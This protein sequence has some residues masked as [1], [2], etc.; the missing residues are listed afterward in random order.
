[1]DI[2]IKI[3]KF[4]KKFIDYTIIE[5]NRIYTLRHTKISVKSSLTRKF[6]QSHGKLSIVPNKIVV[7]NYMG[8]GYGCNPK[9]VTEALLADEKTYDI[10]WVVKNV[11]AKRNEFPEGIRLVEYLS[12]DAMYEYATAKI[13]LC[14]YHLISYFNRGLCKKPGQT[15]IQMWHGSFGIKK[16]EN[17]CKIL[18]EN[19]AWTYLAEK[20]SKNTDY[21]ISNSLF[22]TEIYRRAFWDV[23]GI[24]EFGHPRNDIFFRNNEEEIT[25][26]VK[27]RLDINQKEN[28]V[29]YVPTLREI[30]DFP[31]EGIDVD[32]LT[33]TLEECTGQ[34]WCIVVRLHPRMRGK[35]ENVC[36][37]CTDKIYHG[38][39]YPDIQELLCAAQIVITDYSSCI[40]DFLLSKKPG[41]IYAPDME[42]YNNERGFYY[43]LEETPFPIA[44]DNGQLCENI[45][46]FDN[47]TYQKKLETFLEDKSS[48]EDGRASERVKTLIENILSEKEY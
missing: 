36:T 31:K 18:T 28:I 11:E 35:L 2:K 26:L 16:I 43:K 32:M 47:N 5:D 21:W 39:D 33:K 13:W 12:E 17:D 45:K 46:N 3:K 41:F 20:N 8:Q 40:F 48:V 24:K 37:G 23:K 1:M 42:A 7:D 30:N 6:E 38:D 29:L 14:N 27:R 19:K 44:V 4:I 10:V 15:Y 9:Y 34:S 22:E 25:S